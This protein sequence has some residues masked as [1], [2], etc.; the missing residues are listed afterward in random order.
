MRH[1]RALLKSRAGISTVEFAIILPALLTL[2]C[3]SI[4]LGH[5]LF[6]R[7]VL[8]GAM[9]EAARIST[10][11]LETAEAQRTTVMEESIEQAMRFFPLAAGAHVGVETTVYSD[12]SS[13][14]PETYD[15]ANE[16][17]Q[18]DLGENFVD[19]NAN[20]KWDAASPISGT[21]GGPGDVVSYTVH[22]PKRILFGFLGMNWLM[23]DRI[24]LNATTVVRNESVVRRTS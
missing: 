15:D 6:A 9:T 16:N 10:A 4:E 21:L 18:F 24:T 8:E 22:F 2:I 1:F 19:R 11:S 12:F 13:A 3:G 14:H 7:V 20:G 23:R 17:G 5:M